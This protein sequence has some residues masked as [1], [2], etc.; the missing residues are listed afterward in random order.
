MKYKQKRFLKSILCVML[1]LN[2]CM[3][4]F[5]AITAY[6]AE[7]ISNLPRQVDFS[8]PAP[9]TLEDV[10]LGDVAEESQSE[11]DYVTVTGETG[12]TPA[13]SATETAE[14]EE[15]TKPS[16]TVNPSEVETETTVPA[17]TS[18]APEET[19]PEETLP[20]ETAESGTT[21]EAEE[22]EEPSSETE[23]A[24]TTESEE[25]TEPEG[26]TGVLRQPR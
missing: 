16:E 12:T 14:A 9:L 3:G 13:E 4:D 1:A 25:E 11:T 8:L 20:A 21:E 19:L 6:A 23:P 10:G 17:E 18:E 5:C 26:E 22:T 2:M 7:R 24:E 15:I